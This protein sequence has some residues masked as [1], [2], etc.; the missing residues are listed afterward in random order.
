M[1]QIVFKRTATKNNAKSILNELQT[2]EVKVKHVKSNAGQ[3]A[4][5][6]EAILTV[7]RKRDAGTFS[8][9]NLWLKKRLIHDTL[10]NKNPGRF[11]RIHN[12]LKRRFGKNM[13]K[14]FSRCHL[15]MVTVVGRPTTQ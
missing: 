14:R 7:V 10:S 4:A 13:Q 6:I 15:P 9:Q 5:A 1:T 8:D 11:L 12:R 2:L 3:S